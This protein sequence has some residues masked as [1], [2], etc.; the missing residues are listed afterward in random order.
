MKIDIVGAG[1]LGLILGITLLENGNDVT[2]FEKKSYVGGRYMPFKDNYLCDAGVNFNIISSKYKKKYE[3]NIL[4]DIKFEKLDCYKQINFSSGLTISIKTGEKNIKSLFYSLAKSRN[5]TAI[6]NDIFETL[7]FLHSSKNIKSKNIKSGIFSDIISRFSKDEK[8]LKNYR[9]KTVDDFLNILDS[10]SLKEVI[11]SLAN[12][13]A[14]FMYLIDFLYKLS[15]EDLYII[16]TPMSDVIK[17]LEMKFLKNKGILKCDATI[18]EVY[19]GVQGV[20]LKGENCSHDS[21]YVI[22]ATDNIK[23]VTSLVDEQYI[24]QDIEKLMTSGDIFDSYTITNFILSE[25][26]YNF[27]G[28]NRFVVEKPFIDNSQSFQRKY[29]SVYK[30]TNNMHVYSIYMRGN[31]S[32]W[33][34]NKLL[35]SE[36]KDMIARKVGSEVAKKY[37]D[38]ESM[39][40]SANVI[41]PFDKCR[42]NNI[43]IGSTRGFISTPKYYEREVE[44]IFKNSK[45]FSANI[46]F[47]CNSNLEKAFT[48]YE[49]ILTNF[50]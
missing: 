18:D 49:Y 38:F 46:L 4:K 7:N 22:L 45:V 34:K 31:Y 30:Y 25:N 21:K 16:N 14:S 32:Y 5:D 13:K 1:F 48:N 20:M 11:K 23:N 50:R 43:I 41:T 39:I 28:I 42:E 15:Y 36:A 8:K 6:L 27:K 12:K 24:N 2:I 47:N 26:K 33:E 35:E 9:K 37:T 3:N 29:E 19:I 40:K 10:E 44:L 17:I